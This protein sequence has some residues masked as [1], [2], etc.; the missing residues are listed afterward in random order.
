MQML[1]LILRIKMVKQHYTGVS[2]NLTINCL[3][4][5]EINLLIASEKGNEG[6]VKLL[7]DANADINI[8]D[9]SGSTAFHIG[10]S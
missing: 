4:I 3:K 9:K 6:I 1:M 2:L 10:K 5:K 8:Q 7:I